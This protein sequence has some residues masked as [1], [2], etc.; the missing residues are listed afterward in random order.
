MRWGSGSSNYLSSIVNPAHTTTRAL[1]KKS[2]ATILLFLIVFLSAT[3]ISARHVEDWL[4]QR[5][6]MYGDDEPDAVERR[7]Q[8]V[9]C[10]WFD[11]K[12]CC[13]NWR[14]VQYELKV[15]GAG[16]NFHPNQ[17]PDPRSDCGKCG[18]I[19]WRC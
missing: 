15:T 7:G 2:W 16:S 17:G 5:R 11:W 19:G 13:K 3:T 1:M 18:D 12:C 4:H 8:Y 10:R 14:G 6:Q 9:C